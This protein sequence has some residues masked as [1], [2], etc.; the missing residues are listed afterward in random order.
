M[1]AISVVEEIQRLLDEGKLSQRKIAA[2][3]GVGRGTVGAIASGQRGLYGRETDPDGPH[4]L[5]PQAPPERCPQCGFLVYT[6]CMICST[7]DYRQRRRDERLQ[8]ATSVGANR[9]RV[10]R[11]ARRRTYSS[12]DRPR[13]AR[14]A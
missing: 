2:R 14:V 13:H 8:A 5:V 1:L 4:P 6:P 7:R 11:S 9:Q 10:A 3:L 12:G